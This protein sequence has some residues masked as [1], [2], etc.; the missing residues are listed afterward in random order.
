MKISD[1]RIHLR[2]DHPSRSA[3]E[4]LEQLTIV[5]EIIYSVGEPRTNPKGLVLGG[6]YHQT[7]LAFETTGKEYDSIEVCIKDQLQMIHG[8]EHVI[9]DIVT[10]GGNAMFYI[11]IFCK[12]N[13]GFTIAPDLMAELTENKISLGFD[14]YPEI[15]DEAND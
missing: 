15:D 11:S 13:A 12:E 6:V 3:K 10:S 1:F 8:N 5:P 9:K 2:I 7:S 14:I 4:I